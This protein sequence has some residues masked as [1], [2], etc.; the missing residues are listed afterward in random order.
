MEKQQFKSF[1]VIRFK[2]FTRKS[3]SVFASMNK[4]ITIGVLSGF[5]LASAHATFVNPT[6]KTNI[7]TS[8]DSIAHK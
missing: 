7:T 2:R 8:V 5:T 6:E 1:D 4:A 3:Y